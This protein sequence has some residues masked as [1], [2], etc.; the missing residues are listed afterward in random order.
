MELYLYGEHQPAD[1]YM[2]SLRQLVSTAERS[3]LIAAT[4]FGRAGYL[5]A[6]RLVKPIISEFLLHRFYWNFMRRRRSRKSNTDETR[7]ITRAQKLGLNVPKPLT[8]EEVPIIRRQIYKWAEKITADLTRGNRQ[9]RPRLK[10][11]KK[12]QRAS[13]K[14]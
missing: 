7:N 4:K 10:S 12:S 2:S 1:T 5:S 14:K 9:Y 3:H 13:K 11:Q 8:V 6:P